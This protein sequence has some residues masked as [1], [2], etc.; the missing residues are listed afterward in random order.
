[1]SV[2]TVAASKRS[3]AQIADDVLSVIESYRLKASPFDPKI[4]PQARNTFLPLIQK[5]VEKQT[6]ISLT[7]PA[8]PFKSPNTEDKVLGTLPD[9]AEEVALKHLQGFC[10]NIKD[11][12]APGAELTIVSDGIVYSDLLDVPDSTVWEYGELLRQMAIELDCNSIHFARLSMMPALK[13]KLPAELLHY[14]DTASY[15]KAAPLV[16][17][18][19]METYGERGYDVNK[20][21]AADES[22]KAT[23]MGYLKYLSRDLRKAGEASGE[24]SDSSGVSSSGGSDSD[25]STGSRKAFKRKVSRVSKQMIARGKCYAA[26]VKEAF[27]DSVRL[28][29]HAANSTTK[30]P[31]TVM[32]NVQNR[33]IT[34]WHSVMTCRLDGSF[35]PMTRREVKEAKDLEPVYKA[36]GQLWCYREKSALYDLPSAVSIEHTYPMGLLI[37]YAPNTPFAAADM[38]KVRK[39]SEHNS[40]V[41]L[42][43]L[44]GTTDREA[45]LSKGREMGTIMKWKF[46][47]LLEVKDGGEEAQG[48][49]NVLSAEP[50][51]FHYDGLFKVV[52]GVSTPP[53]FQMFVAVTASPKGHGHTLFATSPLLFQHL[54]GGYTADDLRKHKWC[55]I[56]D[57]FDH[58]R[59]G[60]LPLVVDHPQTRTPCIRYHEFWPQE[61]TRFTPTHVHIQDVDE[62]EDERIRTAI[63]RA[64]FDRRVCLYQGWEKGDVLINDNVLTMHTREGYTSSFGR[65]LWRLHID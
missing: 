23:Y 53:L 34:P 58:S 50:M 31:I 3:P 43:G 9:K 2:H 47:E 61:R 29:I 27:P 64:L 4:I 56:T 14:T 30:I 26:C 25:A 54:T 1:M 65:E 12:Y 28:S 7:L 5:A 39:L 6:P 21:I 33:P 13:D 55:V 63:E 11:A 59:F 45:F 35:I 51:P 22:V 17:E 57:A 41:V 44:A 48:L 52:N 62:A 40:P 46:G 60:D 10:D 20:H 15:E 16:R 49:N 19:L 37:R 38:H 32:P 36:D 18:L 42:R 8:F 24:Q